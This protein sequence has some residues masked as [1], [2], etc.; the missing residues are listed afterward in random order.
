MLI[1]QLTKYVKGRKQPT[2][3]PPTKYAALFNWDCLFLSVYPQPDS[4]VIYGTLV[5]RVGTG[6]SAQLRKAY[7]GWLIEALQNEGAPNPP[8]PAL[9]S[10]GPGRNDDG[11]GGGSSNT[12][13]GASGCGS[14]PKGDGS[15]NIS[16]R[17]RSKDSKRT[18]GPGVNAG[19]A[20][21]HSLRVSGAGM[22]PASAVVRP[23]IKQAQ[24]VRH[25]QQPEVRRTPSQALAGRQAPLHAQAQPPKQ[26][27]H[28]DALPLRQTSNDQQAQTSQRIPKAGPSQPTKKATAPKAEQIK[29]QSA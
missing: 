22:G 17:L 9:L 7:L 3:T 27:Q 20:D 8:L 18:G 12:N 10:G 21:S 6:D 24:P 29:K 25:S 28:Q 5:P 16:D 14:G 1:K 15:G 4:E 11:S 19:S 26:A 2:A 13:P 23:G